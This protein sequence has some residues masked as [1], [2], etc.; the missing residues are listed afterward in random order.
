[1]LRQTVILRIH[2][3]VKPIEKDKELIIG[4]DMIE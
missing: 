2:D 4:N 1:M 3:F